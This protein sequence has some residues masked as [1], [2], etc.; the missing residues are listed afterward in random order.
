MAKEVLKTLDPACANRP[1]SVATEIM[2]YNYADIVFSPYGDYWQQM[3]KICILEMLSPKNVR[4]FASIR[5][6]EASCLVES[7]RS[8]SEAQFDLTEK[9]FLCTSSIT[10]RTA[11]GKVSRDREASIR[12]IKKAIA[13]AG[14]FDLADLFPSVKLFDLISWNKFKLL[15]MRRE[16]DVILDSIIDEHRNNLTPTNKANGELGCE[17]LVDVLLRL[18]ESS[19]LDFPI[20]ND[21]IKAVIF[22]MFSAGTESSST[23]LDWAMA[24]LM[25]NPRVM[26]K[27]QNEMRQ[28][29]NG[30]ETINETDIHILKYLKLVIK[31]TL[32]LHPPI[33]II[34]RACREE[35]EIGG[36]QIP[37]NA[38]VIVNIWGIGRDPNYW[39][40]PESFEPERFE[41]H[42]VDFFGNHFEFLPFGSGK[43]I[44]P[45]MAFG[46]ANIEFLLAQLLYHFD[47]KLPNG[48]NSNDIDMTE[49]D[50]IAVSRKNNLY[51]IATPYDPSSGDPCQDKDI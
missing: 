1:R 19:D 23:T 7:I 32:R 25:K 36:Y 5:K 33:S 14:Q 27:T 20:T 43:R 12:L 31:E 2:W 28:A 50:G 17:D 39:E 26:A 45:G 4:S 18:K 16:L 42:S 34:P 47:W 44:C 46:I 15:K 30:R 10:C 11:F 35:C 49:V 40:N 6:D 48:I 8:T 38:N 3:R 24:E 41:I 51:L 29:F 13:L 21:N 9:I 22:D 37:L